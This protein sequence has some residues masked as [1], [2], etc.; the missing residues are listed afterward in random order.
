MLGHLSWR[1]PVI[2]EL[3]VTLTASSLLS[4]EHEAGTESVPH[5]P[6][7]LVWPIV[8][9]PIPILQMGPQEPRPGAK[10]ETLDSIAI[11]ESASCH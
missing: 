10:S 6:C 3:I 7:S 5:R 1:L 2:N 9:R 11:G 8:R 4:S